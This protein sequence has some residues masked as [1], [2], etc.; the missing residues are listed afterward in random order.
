MLG[1]KIIAKGVNSLLV[2]LL[3]MISY[4]LFPHDNELK[5]YIYSTIISFSVVTFLPIMTIGSSIGYSLFKLH[6]RQRNSL[7]LKYLIIYLCYS[8]PTQLAQLLIHD[9]LGLTIVIPF[10]VTTCAL[11]IEA[12]LLIFVSKGKYDCLD[13]LIGIEY[14]K[15]SYKTHSW[16]NGTL[17]LF[18]CFAF[19]C[20]FS[21]FASFDYSWKN[22]KVLLGDESRDYGQSIFFEWDKL[23]G[24][25]TS[26]F[27]IKETTQDLCC[28]DDLESFIRGKDLFVWTVYI[29]CNK[30]SINNLERRKTL[31]QEVAWSLL[32]NQIDTESI[33]DY[34]RLRF[35]YSNYTSPYSK[36]TIC[37]EYFLDSNTNSLSGG[38]DI[39]AVIEYNELIHNN[40]SKLI[41][42]VLNKTQSDSLLEQY[43]AGVAISLT[44]TIEDAIVYQ[45]IEHLNE[46]EVIPSFPILSFE[47]VAPIISKTIDISFPRTVVDLGSLTMT[48]ERMELESYRNKEMPYSFYYLTEKH[49]LSSFR[50]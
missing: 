12:L 46:D 22:Q 16:T 37:Y 19:M 34:Y 1:K 10:L 45:S 31:A 33:P 38:V 18:L 27:V 36:E 48:P 24:L 23:Y 41:M 49:I 35:Y 30:Y 39:N 3:I 15:L 26:I 40:Y 7:L 9:S 32:Q 44:P 8:F 13:Y 14:N 43:T 42:E 17:L 5:D 28:P 29:S 47:D 50:L 11:S 2:L 4:S 21:V 25:C 20:S 6:S